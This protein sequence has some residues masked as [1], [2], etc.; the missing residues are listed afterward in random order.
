MPKPASHPNP[1]PRQVDL[2][3][4]GFL[5][6]A[7]AAG[8]TLAFAGAGAARGSAA[9]SAAGKAFEPSIWYQIDG[10]GTVTINIAE[11]EMG[12]HVGTA[13]ARILAEEL[14]A[15]WESVRLSYVDTDPKWGTLL[16]GGSWSVWHNFDLLSRAGAAGRLALIEEGARLMG[17]AIAACSA[18][19]GTV[20]SGS[21]SI[22]YAEIVRT[23][24]L[25]RR[26]SPAALRRITLKKPA[27]WRLIGADVK[28]IDVP[29]KVD[30][31]AIY[32]IDARV[33]G[34]LYARPILPPTR[35]G[36]RVVSIDDGD[37]RQIAGYVGTRTLHDPSGVVPGWVIVYGQ[38]FTT[39]NK[40]VAR[41]RIDWEK[42]AAA[43]VTEQNIIDRAEA[44]LD[45]PDAGSLVRNDAGVDQAFASAASILERSYVTDSVL[46]FPME[47]VNALAFENNGRWEVH[48]G[49][50]WQSLIL[51]TLARA[52][53]VQQDKIIMRTHLLGGGFGRR[54]FGDYAVLA[55]LAAKAIGRPVK[56][57]C[58]REDDA[59][60]DCFRS[61]S[62]Q[63]VRMAFD[64]GGAITGMEHHA[65]AGWPTEA[66]SPTDLSPGLN[67]RPFDQF[68]INGAN[69]WY[70]TGK[71][72]VRAVSNDLAIKS[73][74]PGWLR[75]VG[76]GW[77]NWALESFIDEA[78]H[79]LGKDPLALRLQLLKPEGR[80]AGSVPNSSG[81]AGRQAS[82]LRRAAEK[83]GWG[84]PMPADVGLGIATTFGQERAMPTWTACVA[85]VR[86][87]RRSGRVNVEKLTMVVDAGVII[88]P[89]GARAQVEGATLWGLSLALHEGTRF[90]NGHVQDTNL[91]TYTPLRIADVPELDIELL[92]SPHTSVGL[93]EPSTTVVAPA[94]GNA[95]FA[96]VGVR[97]RRLP[98][99]PA[100][101]TQMLQ[102]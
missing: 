49:N 36:S 46:H 41:I 1:Y 99:R 54:L 14:E 66:M 45:T 98:I 10:Q 94:I 31:S 87:D 85:R 50:Q 6:T 26:Y 71:H 86:V 56:L 24:K 48:T 88:H 100:M 4:R 55:A 60:L 92:D 82:V 15:D 75:S 78:A 80:N 79:E 52:L 58:T 33:E 61:P 27:D 19:S 76:P 77:T 20:S 83:A 38:S 101:I 84:R 53:E 63:R 39:V 13:L 28:A 64:R 9:S 44:L 18:R 97:V 2:S 70:D 37:A 91:N 72:R 69:H 21:R 22:T 67:G 89:D 40:A 95:I 62:L 11:A 102:T 43:G 96:A 47:P 68:S 74:L 65:A 59:R 42:G 16:T 23:G 51:P 29:S 7:G 30:G 93:G 32:G 73:F 81:G 57:L 8:I 17:V 3:R 12:Q 34:M 90:N 5:I 35:Y 25:D